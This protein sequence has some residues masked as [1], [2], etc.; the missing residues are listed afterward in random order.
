MEG[1]ETRHDR[2]SNWVRF[3][4]NKGVEKWTKRSYGS[5][6]SPSGWAKNWFRHE[7]VATLQRIVPP[8][9]RKQVN[10]PEKQ[11]NLFSPW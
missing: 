8:R 10:D 4:I 2:G 6:S 7:F 9:W 3:A 1:T 5:T 11:G